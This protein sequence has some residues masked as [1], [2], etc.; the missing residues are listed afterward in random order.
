MRMVTL[1]AV[2][3][4]L[5]LTV[6]VSAQGLGEASLER[7]LAIDPRSQ[8]RSYRSQSVVIVDIGSLPSVK[9]RQIHQV[10]TQGGSVLQKLRI[11]IDASPSM[12]AALQ[13]KQ[14]SSIHVLSAQIGPHGRLML[15]I[16]RR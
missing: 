4:V 14:L 9:Q 5:A 11:A 12:V 3:V 2:A 8:T 7:Q 15:V 6:E 1:V 13:A 16:E 10:V